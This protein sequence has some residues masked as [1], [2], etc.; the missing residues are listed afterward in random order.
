MI[1][2]LEYIALGLVGGTL[3]GILGI[4]GAV[5]LIPALVYFFGFEQH[6]AQ[7]TTLAMMIPPIGLLAMLE[8]YK[9]GYV[10]IKVAA[11]MVVGMFIGGYFGAI[12]ATHIP[13]AT[14]RKIFGVL[15]LVVGFKM[16]MGK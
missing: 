1:E 11:I 14:L 6:T 16:I 13:A 9:A 8:Y 5:L 15:L 2:V 12:I 4:G 3:S 10:N 7:G